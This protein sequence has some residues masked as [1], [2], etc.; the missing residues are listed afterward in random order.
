MDGCFRAVARICQ[1]GRVT[2]D[3]I[4]DALDPEQ[5]RVAEALQRPVCVWRVPGPARPAAITHRLAYGYLRT[6]W[7]PRS[8][9]GDVHRTRRG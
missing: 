6:V 7:C 9:R 4:L 2:P 1:D 8:A 5:R 3:A